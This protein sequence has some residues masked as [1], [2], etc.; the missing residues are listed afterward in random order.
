MLVLLS[1]SAAHAAGPVHPNASW[2]VD[3]GVAV[4]VGDRG[5]AWVFEDDASGGTWTALATGTDADLNAIWGTDGIRVPDP[6]EWV[7]DPVEWVPDPVEWLPRSDWGAGDALIVAGDDGT[8]LRIDADLRVVTRLSS[9]STADLYGV[10]GTDGAALTAV[11]AGGA[12]LTSTDGQRFSAAKVPTRTD[13]YGIWGT[14]GAV[15][16]AGDLGEV[17]WSTDRMRWTRLATDR[18]E[19]L[20]GVWGTD[21]AVVVVGDA[22]TAY[23]HDG[24][25]LY[26][27]HGR[28]TSGDAWSVGGTLDAWWAET[29][30]GLVWFDL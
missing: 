17:W 13:L 22:G 25:A 10:W 9:G 11:G 23:V 5:E 30:K 2:S 26:P 19:T 16:V 15:L 29:D 4:V 1:L 24:H 8:L 6:V 14:D 21:G 28:I 3:R 7:P 27:M 18:T 20:R 12:V